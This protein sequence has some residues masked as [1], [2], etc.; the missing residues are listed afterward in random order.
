[1]QAALSLNSDLRRSFMSRKLHA[2]VALA[3]VSFAFTAAACA[4]VAAPPAP[5]MNI[6]DTTGSNVCH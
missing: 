1:V 3:L 6:C 5:S 4:E 2:L